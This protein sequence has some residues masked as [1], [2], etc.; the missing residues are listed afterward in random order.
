MPRVRV[1]INSLQRLF[2]CPLDVGGCRLP[3]TSEVTLCDKRL[4]KHI[5]TQAVSPITGEKLRLR[6]V[7]EHPVS[8]VLPIMLL[9][10]KLLMKTSWNRHFPQILVNGSFLSRSFH[11]FRTRQ[12]GCHHGWA[13]WAMHD[14]KQWGQCP[15]DLCNMVTLTPSTNLLCCF[16]TCPG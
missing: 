5:M 16:L 3:Y 1:I 11:L 14:Y 8:P 2:S 6:K 12:Q 10:G 4:L 9:T 15:L 7:K 13:S